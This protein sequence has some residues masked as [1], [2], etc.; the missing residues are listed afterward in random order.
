MKG[1]FDK[2]KDGTDNIRLQDLHELPMGIYG[3]FYDKYDIQWIFVC[4]Q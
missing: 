1:G 3:H 2:L 4:R